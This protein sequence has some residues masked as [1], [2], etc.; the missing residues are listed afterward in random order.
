MARYRVLNQ[1]TYMGYRPGE[2]ILGELDP[3][4][5]QR[6]IAR[7]DIERLSNEPIKLDQSRV[8]PPAPAPAEL[9]L[10]PEPVPPLDNEAPVT[11]DENNGG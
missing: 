7:G 6:A 8:T 10:A 3:D 4:A 5:A 9:E 11:T 2:V 1:G